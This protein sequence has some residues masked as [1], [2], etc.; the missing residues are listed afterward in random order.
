MLPRQL[1]VE[2]VQVSKHIE[3]LD[4]TPESTES[5]IDEVTYGAL[6]SAAEAVAGGLRRRGLSQGDAVAIML[7]TCRQ[8]F[9]AFLGLVIV[10]ACR[11]RSTPRHAPRR[12]RSTCCARCTSLTTRRR[13][14]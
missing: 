13:L 5:P 14:P 6:S 7:P 12:W 3:Y 4:P 8:Y 9:E 10:A 1:V 2:K 11:F